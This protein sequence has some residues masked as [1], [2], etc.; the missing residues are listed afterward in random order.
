MNEPKA[1]SPTLTCSRE[2][3][4]VA[5]CLEWVCRCGHSF[6]EW[7][8]WCQFSKISSINEANEVFDRY[9]IIY[10][11]Q[12]AG[13]TGTRVNLIADVCLILDYESAGTDYSLFSPF[14]TSSMSPWLF[15]QSSIST[16]GAV[17]PCSSLAH[18]LWVS[19][20][21]SLV[22]SKVASAIGS[23]P[24]IIQSTQGTGSLRVTTPPQRPSLSVHTYS[25]A[26]SLS[27]WV[28]FLGRILLRSS[29]SKSVAKPSR[30]QQYV[31]LYHLLMF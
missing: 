5:L 16:G 31:L 28:L 11:F 10:V 22:V 26:A 14:N 17:G 4:L 19:G 2:I 6:A 24:T 9:Y 3:I 25:C 18:F 27:P 8:S 20:C 13:L 7:I 15:L 12:G 30:S 29:R 1:P 23:I 21:S